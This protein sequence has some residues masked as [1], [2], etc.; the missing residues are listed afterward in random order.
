MYLRA[1]IF[2]SLR[3]SPRRARISVVDS[4]SVVE[5]NSS[6]NLL[7]P[8]D[9]DEDEC[10]RSVPNLRVLQPTRSFAKDRE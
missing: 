9:E 10:L 2:T 1:C 6:K 5:Q 8:E 3:V 4:I 7:R